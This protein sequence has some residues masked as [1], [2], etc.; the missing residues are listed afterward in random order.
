[1]L[2]KC[3]CAKKQ[4]KKNACF[5][6]IASTNHLLSHVHKDIKLAPVTCKP[7][8]RQKKKKKQLSCSTLKSLPIK[9]S[10]KYQKPLEHLAKHKTKLVQR[11]WSFK[12]STTGSLLFSQCWEHFGYS[13]IHIPTQN[14]SSQSTVHTKYLT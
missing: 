11:L 1:M 14:A 10:S 6:I 2:K 7:T 12:C 13:S 9:P 4:E 8:N 3:S 5:P